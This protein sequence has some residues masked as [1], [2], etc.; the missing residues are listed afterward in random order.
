MRSVNQEGYE[1][2]QLW[3]ILR[4]CVRVCMEARTYALKPQRGLPMADM[5]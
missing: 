5:I 3:H 2:K 4:N 1:S